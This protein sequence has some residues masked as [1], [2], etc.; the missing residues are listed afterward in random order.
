MVLP[1]KETLPPVPD[2]T[3]LSEMVSPFGSVSLPSK[4]AAPIWSGVFSLAT[5]PLSLLATGGWGPPLPQ[6]LKT[7]S[8]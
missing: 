3:V 6:G 1:L 7:T 4:V 5:I 8:T 2:V